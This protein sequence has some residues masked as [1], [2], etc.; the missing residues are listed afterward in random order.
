MGHR[1]SNNPIEGRD[2]KR[3]LEYN[4]NNIDIFFR[5][6]NTKSWIHTVRSFLKYST[7]QKKKKKYF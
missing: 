5:T 1:T 7:L 6:L 2:K 4:N 3:K